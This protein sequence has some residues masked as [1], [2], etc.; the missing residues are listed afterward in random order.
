MTYGGRPFHRAAWVNLRHGTATMDTLVSLG[1]SVAFGWSLWGLVTL[2]LDPHAAHSGHSPVYFEVA[3]GVTA[4]VLA[5][6]YLEARARRRAGGALRALI[7]A[8]AKD[9]SLLADGREIRVPVEQVRVGDQFVVRPG[10]KMATDGVVVDGWSAVD[11]SLVT[12]EATPV[13]VRTGDAVVGATINVSG[14]LVVRAT[15]VGADTVLAQI[16]RLVEAAQEGKARVQRLA[17]R[18]SAICVPVVLVLAAVTLSAW[19]AVGAEAKAAIR[20][21]VAVLIIACPCALGLATPTALLVGTGRG[22]MI[23][24]LIRGPEALERTRRVDTVVLDKTGTVTT[25]LMT[26]HRTVAAEGEDAGEVLA[27]AGALESASRHPIAQAISS[28]ACSPYEAEG[29]RSLPGLGVEGT[30]TG[31]SALGRTLRVIQSNLFWAFAYN[32]AALPV[33]AL[34]GL[35]PMIAGGAMALSSVFVVGNS[36]RLY[37]FRREVAA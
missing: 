28:A 31:R 21:A 27:V 7:A 32:L 23:G 12:G 33:A 36:L 1:T 11:A 37:G 26:L 14:R 24:I 5:G 6:R 13:E 4:F 20:S 25:G 34:G 19:L 18:V 3:A 29:F 9:V 15:R 22:A 35:D 8:G 17:D 16:T 30:V 2:L 10:E